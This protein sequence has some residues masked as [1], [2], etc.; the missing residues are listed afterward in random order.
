MSVEPASVSAE[1]EIARWTRGSI[2][3]TT[4]EVA[5]EMPVA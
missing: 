2:T 5:E 4:D 1:V 3:R